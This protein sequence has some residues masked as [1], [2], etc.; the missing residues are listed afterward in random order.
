MAIA[1]IFEVHGEAAFRDG[2]RRVI[3]RLLAG[4]PQVLATGGGLVFTG[5]ALE[6]C[7]SCLTI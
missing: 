4:G 6:T 5:R 1:D 7:R 3:Q 2:E